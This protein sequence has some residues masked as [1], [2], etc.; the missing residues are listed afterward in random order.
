[1]P[2]QQQPAS[3]PACLSGG[4]LSALNDQYRDA[5]VDT[6]Q[7]RLPGGISN[8]V[9]KVTSAYTRVQDKEKGVCPKGETFLRIA[10][11]VISPESVGGVKVAG[12][13]TTQKI[14]ALCAT[15]ARVIDGRTVDEVTIAQ[16]WDAFQNLF[17]MLGIMSP[18][19]GTPDQAVWAY[20]QSACAALVDPQHPVFISFTTESWKPPQRAGESAADYA[21]REPIVME[22]WHGLA[23]PELV[24]QIRAGH[25]P[26]AGVVDTR[27]IPPGTVPAGGAPTTNRAAG[28]GARP[29]VGNT[30][31]PAPARAPFSEPPNGVVDPASVPSTILPAPQPRA[32]AGEPHYSD[33]EEGYS[34]D[35]E[36]QSPE[37][38]ADEV[39]ALVEI[40]MSDP[41]GDTEDAQEAHAR[42]EELAWEQ[43]W[44]HE[45]TGNADDWEQVG[46]MALCAPSDEGGNNPAVGLAEDEDA[47][48]EEDN[49]AV[50]PTVTVG[51]R[52]L[53]ARRKKDGV[54][55]Q[56][57]KGDLFPLVEVEVLTSDAAAR[58]CTIR[59]VADGKVFADLRTKQPTVISWDWLDPLG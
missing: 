30:A 5:P 15:P 29:H 19:K 46:R 32:L 25:H 56:N 31:P 4:R 36:E 34:S 50:A 3:L 1:M 47:E 21:R 39:A 44:T 23:L 38:L 14:V 57:S 48:E 22:R 41:H 45:Q 53:Y 43:G 12:V 26:G 59:A 40:A 58:T 10:A 52:W 37:D 11:T 33:G 13:C 35:E 8:G 54:R 2:M 24:E 49:D 20:Y 42:L 7:R 6:G 9:A 17:K 16:Q 51:S 55:M 27:A 28:N 18:P